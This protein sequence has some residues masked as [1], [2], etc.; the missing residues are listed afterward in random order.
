MVRL[1]RVVEEGEGKD[2]ECLARSESNTLLRLSE[3]SY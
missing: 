1:V 2:G 3:V